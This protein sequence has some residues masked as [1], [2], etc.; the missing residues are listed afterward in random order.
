MINKNNENEIINNKNEDI[1]QD[2]NITNKNN[3][4]EIINN[5]NEGIKQD[6]NI[7]NKNNENEIINNDI[8]NLNNNNQNI[9]NENEI[10]NNDDNE[11]DINNN[12][13][14]NNNEN[15][16]INNDDNEIDIN[17]NKQ[18]YNNLSIDNKSINN[19]GNIQFNIVLLADEIVNKSYIMK[20]YVQDK[21]VESEYISSIIGF[22]N[23]EK[24]I[25]INDL[26]ITLNLINT[27]GQERFKTIT[28]S[29]YEN[30]NVFIIFFNY[31]NEESY[32]SVKLWY[33]NIDKYV[34]NI[35]NVLI[36]IVGINPQNSIDKLKNINNKEFIMNDL[37]IKNIEFKVCK[38]NDI[39][40]IRQ[41]FNDLINDGYKKFLVQ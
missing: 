21:I 29:I 14:N 18:I 2:N 39:D 30:S 24:V 41:L 27:A 40:S 28:K 15:E 17:N 33:N 26:K 12:N 10:I 13:Q 37:N 16:I 3:E 32:N 22:Q 25:N 38:E 11:I 34:N 9:K 23:E 19:E 7:T 6:N 5:K 20:S 4:N 31:G 35:N 36:Y 1:K 8:K